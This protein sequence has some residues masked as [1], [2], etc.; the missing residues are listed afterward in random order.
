[1]CA[2]P[3]AF[4]GTTEIRSHP[5]APGMMRWHRL[6]MRL[7]EVVQDM[8]QGER[9]RLVPDGLGVPDIVHD[10]VADLLAAVLVA[11]EVLGERGRGD[12]RQVLVLGDGEHLLLGQAAES[13]A[14]VKC[15]HA[16]LHE[17]PL[18]RPRSPQRRDHYNS[19]VTVCY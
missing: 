19:T 10:H 3:S 6:R 7:E 1:M 13:D 18:P 11:H 12:L 2:C 14:V 17:G 4:A 9:V 8:Q 5:P 15:D 16:S